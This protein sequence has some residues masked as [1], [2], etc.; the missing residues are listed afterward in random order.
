MADIAETTLKTARNLAVAHIIVG[1]LLICFGIS[2]GTMF[3]IYEDYKFWTGSIFWWVWI[4]VW[5]SIEEGGR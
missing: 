4:G 2:D 3:E 1:I 5:V